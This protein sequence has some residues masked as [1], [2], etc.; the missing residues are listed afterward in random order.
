MAIDALLKQHFKQ[1]LHILF[2]VKAG[3]GGELRLL[4]DVRCGADRREVLTRA[5]DHGR[6]QI[7]PLRFAKGFRMDNHLMLA[8]TVATPS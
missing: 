7:A 3:I 1:H 4:E 2:G 5:L 8:S 6:K